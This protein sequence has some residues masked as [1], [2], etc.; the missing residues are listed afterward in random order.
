MGETLFYFGE[1]ELFRGSGY[2]L[3]GVWEW[4]RKAVIG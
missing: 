4:L 1:G 3:G 2:A